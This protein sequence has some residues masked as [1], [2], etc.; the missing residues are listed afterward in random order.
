MAQAAEI[1]RSTA[2]RLDSACSAAQCLLGSFSADQSLRDSFAP[3]DGIHT[4]GA[5]D[6]DK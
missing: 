1:A 6:S 5:S 3:T 2:F 4:D